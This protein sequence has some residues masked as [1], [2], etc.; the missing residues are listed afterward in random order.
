MP[1]PPSV[2]TISSLPNELLEAIA[3]AGQ[4]AR[5]PHLQLVFKSEWTLSHVSR[6]F[7]DVIIGAPALWTLIEAN[8]DT[9]G[10]AEILGLYLARSNTRDISVSLESY[11]GSTVDDTERHLT[12]ER[13]SQIVPH[14]SRIWRLSC[15]V[16]ME[17]L[18]P[19]RHVRAPILQ[20]LGIV[21]NYVDDHSTRW[22]SIELLSAGAPELTFLKMDGC[23]PKIP[24]PSWTASLT[25]LEFWDGQDSAEED[26]TP[27]LAAITEQCSFLTHVYLDI[28]WMD[29]TGHRLHIPSLKTLHISISECEEEDYLLGIVDLLETPALT[30]LIIDNARCDQVSALFNAT[31]LPRASFPAMTSLSL[32]NGGPCPCE[33]EYPFSD[34]ISFPPAGFFPALSSLALINQCLATTLV[35]NILRQDAT[36]PWP[37]LKT[38]T[39]CPQGTFLADVAAALRDGMHSNLQRSHTLPKSL[40]R[41]FL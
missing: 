20:Q 16:S 27:I 23:K 19:L 18:A 36:H 15:T 35:Q 14:I 2:L 26:A 1:S 32:V 37:Q 8:L 10:S 24:A 28:N 5:F 31:S 12:V 33:A 38:V 39:L 30:K 17:V 40:L 4:Q 13:L 3:A 41:S 21:R 9:A 34:L 7:R 29:P 6:R 25:H 11:W 22:D